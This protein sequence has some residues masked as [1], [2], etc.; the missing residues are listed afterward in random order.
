LREYKIGFWLCLILGLMGLFGVGD[1]YLGERRRGAFFLAWTVGLYILLLLVVVIHG[2]AFLRGD[3][4]P[5]WAL[6]YGSSV[7][8]ISWAH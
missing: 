4:S 8:E 7:A 5:A 1:F 2:F 6:G 3:L